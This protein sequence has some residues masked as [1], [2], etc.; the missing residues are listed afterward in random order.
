MADR[1]S[2]VM[3]SLGKLLWPNRYQQ[4]MSFAQLRRYNLAAAAL[5]GLQAVIVLLI[6]DP[7]RGVLP[8]TTNYLAQDK[9]ATAA[10]GY[11]VSVA[12]THHLFDLNIAY[13]VAAFFFVSALGHLAVASFY[14]RRYESD[15]KRG[16][17]R[18]RWI[19]YSFSI[20][21]MMVG[22]ALLTGIFDISSLIMVFALTAIMSLMGLLMEYR[23]ENMKRVDWFSYVVGLASGLVPW[24]VIF[25]YLIS[26]HI[27]GNGIPTFVYWIYASILVLFYS[28]AVNMYLQ[29]KQ[30]GRWSTYLAGERAY[31]ILSVVAK[32]AL[33]WQIFAGTLR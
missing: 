7:L 25:I 29:Y 3:T 33:A 13:I 18:I 12:A 1:R 15:L 16:I 20:S 19:E 14:R 17:N 27:Y 4:N 10:A 8:V 28:F 6:S 2:G 22:I 26:A 30:L 21:I 5:H 24:L 31:I 11:P 23:N 32:T 9:L